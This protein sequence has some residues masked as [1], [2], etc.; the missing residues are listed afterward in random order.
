MCGEIKAY[1]TATDVAIRI[2]AAG[3]NKINLPQIQRVDEIRLDGFFITGFNGAVSASA[4]LQI[5]GMSGMREATINSNNKPGCLI[6]VD[7]NN[8][9]V[10][11]SRPRV[12]ATG[13]ATTV[14]NFDINLVMPSG[15]NA[16]FTEACFFITFVCRKSPEEMSE[17]RQLMAQVELPQ[18]KGP[19]PR[20]SFQPL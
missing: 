17:Y 20:N 13:S 1:Q 8:P 10:I 15:A 16:S 11:F 9:H 12:L 14:N 18:M 5:S 19:D 2:T 6:A 4:Y 7:V 3:V